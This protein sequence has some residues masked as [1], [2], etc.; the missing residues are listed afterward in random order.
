MEKTLSII[1]LLFLFGCSEFISEKAI[2]D[3]EKFCSSKNGL[4]YIDITWGSKKFY[5][6]DGSEINYSTYKEKNNI[7]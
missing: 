3:A 6:N 2:Q 7:K 1:I 5:C 4:D